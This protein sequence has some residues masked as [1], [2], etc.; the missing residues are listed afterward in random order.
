M[1]SKVFE[2]RAPATFIV[3]MATQMEAS[4]EAE[5]WLLARAGYGKTYEEQ[6][7]Y[8]LVQNVDGG[9]NKATTDPYEQEYNEIRTAHQFIIKHFDELKCGAV[10]DV[11]YI[12]GIT[13]KP[14]ITE[15][16]NSTWWEEEQNGV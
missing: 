16:Y 9:I 4:T 5:R 12:L 3:L 7:K 8:Y 15:R 11:E 1:R 14:K 10:I 6:G 13:D 2:M